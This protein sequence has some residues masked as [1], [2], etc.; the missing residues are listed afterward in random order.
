MEFLRKK[1]A[2]SYFSKRSNNKDTILLAKDTNETGSKKFVVTQKK[3]LYKSIKYGDNNFYEFWTSDMEIKFSLDIDLENDIDNPKSIVL[4]NANNVVKE[5]RKF[6]T[7]YSLN[8]V[9]FLKSNPTEKKIN[10]YHI[11]FNKIKFK[12]HT[13]CNNFFAYLKTKYDMI[14]CDES[15]YNMTVLR[16]C[17]CTKMSQNN[18][19]RPFKFKNIESIYEKKISKSYFYKTL[20]TNVQGCKVLINKKFIKTKKSKSIPTKNS[21]D[22]SYDIFNERKLELILKKLPDKYVDDYNYWIKIGMILHNID[23]NYFKLGKIGVN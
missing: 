9:I 19:L 17:Y 5:L 18:A 7:G 11:V 4:E 1:E 22:K 16:C 23:E 6:S 21:K 12:N 3:K 20:V 8:N 13:Y 15:I 10:S 14:G 2:I